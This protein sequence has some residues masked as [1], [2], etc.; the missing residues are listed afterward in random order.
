MAIIYKY[1]QDTLALSDFL[2]GTDRSEENVMRSFKVS[3]VVNTILAS[4]NNSTV[5]SELE[6]IQHLYHLQ[7]D[8]SQRRVPL[9]RVCLPPALPHHSPI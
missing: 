2:I 8:P 4:L 7:A 9:L 6:L 5:T 3:E 1:P